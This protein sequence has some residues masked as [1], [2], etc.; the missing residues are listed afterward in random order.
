MATVLRHVAEVP[1][2]HGA[3]LEIAEEDRRAEADRAQPL[4]SAA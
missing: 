1:A 3:D 2:Q 4:A